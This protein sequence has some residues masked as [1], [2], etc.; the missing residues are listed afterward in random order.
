[1]PQSLPQRPYKAPG[2][3]SEKD[4]R[5]EEEKARNMC[6]K[7]STERARLLQEVFEAVEVRE[8]RS[9]AVLVGIPR[10]TWSTGYS[11]RS[12]LILCRKNAWACL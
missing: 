2:Y 9:P 12:E 1:M 4:R 7:T 3:P 10:V 11:K 8:R 5:T 6:R